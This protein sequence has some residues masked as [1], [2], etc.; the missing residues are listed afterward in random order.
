V[1]FRF[2]VYRTA[3]A[4]GIRGWVRN[5]ENGDVEIEAE[6]GLEALTEFEG[7]VR[8]GPSFAFVTELHSREVPL[9]E[10]ED[11]SIRR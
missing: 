10:Y 4:L 5:V 7:R 1:G 11:F 8:S 3:H 6:G 2:F 9:T